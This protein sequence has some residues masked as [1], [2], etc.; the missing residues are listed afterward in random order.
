MFGKRALN[1][2][3]LVFKPLFRLN[4]TT[5]MKEITFLT[6]FLMNAYCA[7]SQ[8][9]VIGGENI[10]ISD[11][12]YQVSIQNADGHFCGGAL[13]DSNWVLTGAHC[14][15]EKLHGDLLIYTGISSLSNK[16]LGQ[17]KK[18]SQ[19]LL[20]SNFNLNSLENDLALLK[21]ESPVNFS[22][23]TKPINLAT[24]EDEQNQVLIAGVAAEVSGWGDTELGTGTSYPDQLQAVSVSIISNEKANE[25]AIYDGRVKNTNIVAGDLNG[26]KDACQGDSGGPLTVEKEG[27]DIL[28]GIVSWGEGC[29]NANK[30]GVYTKVSV[31]F[32]WIQQHIHPAI[33][34]FEVLPFYLVGTPVQVIN[35]SVNAS[36]YHWQVKTG[37]GDYTSTEKDGVFT[38]ADPGEYDLKLIAKNDFTSDTI[39]KTI[40]IFRYKHCGRLEKESYPLSGTYADASSDYVL[41]VFQDFK[42]EDSVNFYLEEMSFGLDVSGMKENS[43]SRVYIDIYDGNQNLLNN[44]QDEF[45]PAPVNGIQDYILDSALFLKKN[46]TIEFWMDE[47]YDNYEGIE[48]EVVQSPISS[49]GFIDPFSGQSYFYENGDYYN[50]NITLKG[51]YLSDLDVMLSEEKGLPKK[52]VSRVD[53][54]PNPTNGVLSVNQ[55]ASNQAELFSSEGKTIKNFQLEKGLS[56]IDL[57]AFRN[58]VYYLKIEGKTEKIVLLK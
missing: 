43:E 21:L 40:S 35:N 33:A 25:K 15:Y 10:L 32:N 22:S 53:V 2:L 54:F 7:L 52:E 44:L 39:M 9:R 18:V 13:I 57:S 37:D 17:Q 41:G 29:A 42:L 34:D 1:V 36:E 26:G 28:A 11:K 6:L 12:P 50:L 4:L 55:D 49:A 20:H 5:K 24:P 51:C 38:F 58:G 30:P 48:F 16:V 27:T 45:K 46:F 56:T 3:L 31:Y 23:T 8:S 19:I 14:V 47:F